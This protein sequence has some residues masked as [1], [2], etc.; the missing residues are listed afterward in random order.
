MLLAEV[1]RRL[2]LFWR[3]VLGSWWASVL[4]AGV[5]WRGWAICLFWL[6]ASGGC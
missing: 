2:L 4:D 6:G 5:D 1:S 3:V